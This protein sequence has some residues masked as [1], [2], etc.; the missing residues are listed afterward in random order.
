VKDEIRLIS[1]IFDSAPPLRDDLLVYRGVDDVAFGDMLEG[2]KVGEVFGDKGFVSTTL[3][4]DVAFQ[5]FGGDVTLIE[6]VIPAGNRVVSPLAM[7]QDR[8]LVTGT[9]AAEQE[10]MINAGSKFKIVSK[11]GNMIRVVLLNG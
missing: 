3:K 7:M 4:R 2:L 10:V 1:E 6:V 9:M 8:S 5:D 11:V